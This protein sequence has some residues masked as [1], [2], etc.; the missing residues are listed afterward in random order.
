MPNR[1][2]FEQ[3]LKN[4]GSIF[5]V[6]IEIQLQSISP[7]CFRTGKATLA[8]KTVIDFEQGKVWDCRD[9]QW[10]GSEAKSC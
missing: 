2:F 6:L 9:R 7:D 3:N 8:T 10:V 1:P 4:L 5:R